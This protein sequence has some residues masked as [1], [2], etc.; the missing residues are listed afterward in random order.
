[1]F[2]C[3]NDLNRFLAWYSEKIKSLENSDDLADQIK[4]GK[5]D[6]TLGFLD[7][8]YSWNMFIIYS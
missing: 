7:Q 8:I 6:N 1:M 5:D 2:H 3:F 4:G